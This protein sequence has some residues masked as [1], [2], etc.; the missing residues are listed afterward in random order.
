MEGS[1]SGLN[2]TITCTAVMA[3][4]VSSSLV[5]ISWTGG[6]TLS[7]SPRVTLSHQ[8]NNMSQYTRT[9]TFSPLLNVDAGRY[10]CFVLVTDYDEA[11]T[12]DSVTIAVN[13]ME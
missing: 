1:V 12:S 10:D 6:S 9:V 8:S 11:T 4:G 3:D 5:F 13:G 7:E 2:S